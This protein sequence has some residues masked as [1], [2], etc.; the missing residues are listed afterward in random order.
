V[1]TR[2]QTTGAIKVYVDGTLQA[3]GT[4]GRNTLKSSARLLFG[5]IASGNGYFNG[6]LDDIKIF[7][8]TLSGNEVTALYNNDAYPPAA[9]PIHLTATAGNAQVAL[10]WAASAGTSYNVKRSLIDGGP[11]TTITN[12]ASTTFTDT[13]VLNNRTYY[14]VVSAVN[15]QG[16][17]GNSA[18][19]SVGTIPMA[20]WFKADALTNLANGAPVAVWPDAT[21]N[22]F[23]AIQPL[24]GNRPIFV[25]NGMNGQPVV[26]FNA[27]NSSYLWFY[28]PVQDDFT[29][30]VVFKST[31]GIGTGVNFY[32]G[33]GL[34]N[35]EQSGV[36]DDFGTSLNAYGQ[37]LAGTGH[38][39]TSI[40]SSAGFT[41]G[42]PHV[43]TFKRVKGTGLISL[44]VDGTLVSLGGG[45]TQSLTS[46]NFLIIG[47]QAV[48]NN[49]LTG[50]I[51]EVQIYNSALTDADRI[52]Q[53]KALKCKYGITGATALSAPTGLAGSAGNRQIAVNWFLM[54][55]ATSYNLWR[56]TDD[57]ATY[58]LVASNLTTSSYLDT[59]AANG[60]MNYYQVAATDACGA[61]ANSLSMNT[62]LSLPALGMNLN[63]TTNA[64]AINWPGW[65][66]DW[67]LYGA[68][69]LTPPVI[70]SP[71]TNAIGSNNG[72]FN[73]TLPLDSDS[74]FY[75]LSSP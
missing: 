29:M 9:A 21:G 13:N 19:V 75:R 67:T 36:T 3:T 53:E 57:G 16:E 7:R 58:Q 62:L 12:L 40:H 43:M 47:G 2:Q 41:N 65:A 70:W 64:L 74:H 17:G 44:Y 23:N 25:A 4:A 73:V 61:S 28:R 14:Y 60:Q 31:Q 8:R 30:I 68:T 33:A 46:P 20:A 51:A 24:S 50:D 37:V 49:F 66:N 32:E 10:S 39:D 15:V 71:V 11:Y 52:G 54:P 42:L 55:G 72:V 45:G 69:N 34:V 56:S 27:A 18:S 22:A 26:R 5:S 38:P 63:A 6:S 1:A 59:T 35:G 48:L